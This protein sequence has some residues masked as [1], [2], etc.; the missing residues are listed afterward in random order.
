[1]SKLFYCS[2]NCKA[3]NGSQWTGQIAATSG[4]ERS[5]AAPVGA[6]PHAAV[7]FEGTSFLGPHGK[8][9]THVKEI[10]EPG[11]YFSL[12]GAEIWDSASLKR[13]M[14]LV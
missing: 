10:G 2:R 5:F 13:L 1:M 11:Q 9:Q 6:N 3:L 14:S 4:F 8:R 7:S 12:R